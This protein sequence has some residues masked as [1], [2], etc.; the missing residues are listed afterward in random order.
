MPQDLIFTNHVSEAIDRTVSRLGNK[1]AFVITDTNTASLA[2]PLIA[3]RC[4][5]L[6]TA[7]T[8]SLPA[9]DANK[10]LDSLSGIWR[11]LS[12]SGATRSSIVINLGGGM[13]TDIG[14]FAAATFK[15]GLRFINVPTTLL[16]AVDAAVGGKTG[17]NFS[18]LKNEV[19]AF[20]PADAVIISTMFF[21]SLPPT[22]VKSGYAEMIKH[23]LLDGKK[24]LAD[25][26]KFD[27]SD[28]MAD[29]DALL[30]LLE[31]SVGVKARIVAADP[32]ETGLRKALNL[33]H[34][35]GH[36]FESFAMTEM[37][38]PIP[39]G[40]AVAWGMVVELI[41]SHMMLRF[42]A[43]TLHT[44]AAYVKRTYGYFDI[45]CDDYPRLIEI[46]GHD[47][48]NTSPDKINFTLLR[49]PGQPVTDLTASTDDIRAALDIYRDL[50]A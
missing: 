43:E 26:L 27:I 1:P 39:H 9:G 41:L 6:A 47:K 45:D 28:P 11:W 44:V 40:Y 50:L 5:A 17:I 35:V 42:P 15:R 14:G 7:K 10:G 4:K 19:G 12:A 38:S 37:K 24:A 18:G 3:G 23:G 13:I 34:T 20:A 36:A 25:L 8:F 22:E 16:G 48:K 29:P 21:S 46:M 31:K 30:A 49:S 33:G 2:L 32:K